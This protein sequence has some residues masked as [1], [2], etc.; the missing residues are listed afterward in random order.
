MKLISRK[1]FISGLVTC[2]LSVGFF[3][4]PQSAS[5]KAPAK[6][7]VKVCGVASLLTGPAIAPTGAITVAAGNNASFNSVANKTYY[8]A[9]GTHTLSSGQFGQIIPATGDT[10][11]GA[12]GA[13]IDGQGVNAA[14][15]TQQATNVTISYL[16]IQNFNSE[17]DQGVVNHDSGN[18]WTITH[19][20]IQNNHGGAGAMAGAN[21]TVQYNCFS[22][23]GQYA[24]NAYQAAGG[25]N[26][27]LIDHNEFTNNDADLYD[28]PGHTGCGCSGAMKLW[29]T[30]DSTIT[31]NWFHGDQS[32]G[33]W[34]DT[35]N[36]GVQI[37]GNYIDGEWAEAIFYEISYNAKII[38]NTILN[39]A[40]GKG[41]LTGGFPVA[42]IYI[43]ESGAD[44]RVG[45][46]FKTSMKIATNTLTDNWGGIV[47]WENADRFCRATDTGDGVC[48]LVNPSVVTRTSC[49]QTNINNPPYFN[50]CR[51]KTQNVLVTGNTISLTPAHVPFCTQA[52]YCGYEG[53]FSQYGTYPSWSP[54]TANT[55]EDHITFNQ[56][57]K[58]VNNIYNGT[59]YFD[60]HE[61]GNTVS[62]SIWQS[63]Y[64]QDTGSIFN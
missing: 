8:F 12:P 30:N 62:R 16:T 1:L 61:Q 2:A 42:A 14:A 15:F 41:P 54:Y 55:V 28:H 32:T 4:A 56:N 11:I 45:D 40:W 19:N 3:V 38:N 24:I 6:P 18:G 20:T 48:T 39:S 23:N 26:H 36:A 64:G 37:S 44:K 27:L 46:R 49:N 50:D 63:T 57:N 43:S 7:P 59:V 13:I 60:A 33:I 52:N 9:S 21:Q 31:K 47:L 25:I 10:F 53:L 5:A 51:W 29:Q 22:G 58:W 35:D 34:A 17:Q